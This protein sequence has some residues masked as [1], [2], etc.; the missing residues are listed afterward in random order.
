[1]K[2]RVQAAPYTNLLRETSTEANKT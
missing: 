2:K 1:V